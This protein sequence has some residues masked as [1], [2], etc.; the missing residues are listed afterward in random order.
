LNLPFETYKIKC[1]N[2]FLSWTVLLCVLWV[3]FI[4]YV[5]SIIMLYM[6]W[7]RNN[8]SFKKQKQKVFKY[9][10]VIVSFCLDECE[11][12]KNDEKDL[13]KIILSKSSSGTHIL[14]EAL[15]RSTKRSISVYE[16]FGC[17][18]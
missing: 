16:C 1:K 12:N 9:Y 7:W 11:Y 14:I 5:L 8:K 17:F 15:L 13:L 18:G 2:L 3:Y 10:W 4:L 6:H